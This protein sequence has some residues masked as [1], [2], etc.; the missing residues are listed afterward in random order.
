MGWRIGLPRNRRRLETN[1]GTVVSPV[2]FRQAPGRAGSEP[3]WQQ[4]NT[5]YGG[6]IYSVSINRMSSASGSVAVTI[7]CLRNGVFVAFGMDQSGTTNQVLRPIFTSDALVYQCS[8]RVDIQALAIASGES[9]AVPSAN[10]SVSAIK[11]VCAAFVTDI[12]A[13]LNL[14]T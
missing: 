11:S 9:M 3:G 12:E 2:R 1:R 5:A 14:I 10:T 4:D 13:L 8:E 6:W 7:G